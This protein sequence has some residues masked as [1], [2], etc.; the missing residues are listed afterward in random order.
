IEIIKTILEVLR[1]ELPDGDPRRAHINEDLITYVEDR[2]GHDRR[3]AIAPD[4]IKKEIGWEPETMF[5]EGIRKTIKWYF[6]N[7]KWMEGVTSGDYQKYYE[8][9][10]GSRK[11]I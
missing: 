6:E 8:N 4:K 9:M 2:K 7:Q 3:Y 5:K 10:Y 1:E 11:E